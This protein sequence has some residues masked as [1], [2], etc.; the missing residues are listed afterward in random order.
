MFF[1]PTFRKK[2]FTRKIKTKTLDP[3]FY[4]GNFVLTFNKLTKVT[5]FEILSFKKFIEHYLKK[6]MKI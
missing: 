5:Q 4:Y 1:L 6:Q 3:I 2:I